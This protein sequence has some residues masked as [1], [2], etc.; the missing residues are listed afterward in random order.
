MLRAAG[1]VGFTAVAGCTDAD[2]H[3][4]HGTNAAMPPVDSV[5][6]HFCGI[7]VAK[8]NPKFQIVTEHYC[9]H[10]GEDMHQCILYE[11]AEK[12][13]FSRIRGQKDRL[14][15]RGALPRTPRFE[16]HG[17]DISLSLWGCG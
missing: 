10:A 6:L 9:G 16:S 8:N 2:R 7:H 13:L 15:P 11:S 12:R 5:H 1:M 14:S 17:T 4:N 3:A